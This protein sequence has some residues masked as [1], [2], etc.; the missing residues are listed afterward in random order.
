MKIVLSPQVRD[1]ALTLIR[2][3]DTLIINGEPFDFSGIPDGATLPA[4]AVNSDW[5]VGEVH[6]IG[7][8]LHV[9]VLF[10]IPPDASAAQCFPAPIIDPPNGLVTLPAKPEPLFE[11]ETH[12]DD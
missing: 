1:D 6:R 9:S 3:G 12:G 4:G 5:I 7:G 2:S 10:P 11:E 8:E